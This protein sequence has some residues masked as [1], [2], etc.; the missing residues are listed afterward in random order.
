MFQIV[1]CCN[2]FC[3]KPSPTNYQYFF[4]QR[5]L[6][7]PIPLTVPENCLKIDPEKRAF[8]SLFQSLHLSQA[9]EFNICYDQYCPSL[10]KKDA[11]EKTTVER[12]T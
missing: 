8:R 7:L 1:K 4:P 11:K 10:Q 5:F 9:L 3:C 2:L 6:L 12:R